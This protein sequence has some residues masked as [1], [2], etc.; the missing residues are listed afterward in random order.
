MNDR[1]FNGLS[2]LKQLY[3]RTFT[4]KADLEAQL[5]VLTS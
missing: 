4:H 5:K 3:D 2:Y 1:G